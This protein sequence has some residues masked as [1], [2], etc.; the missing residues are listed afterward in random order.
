MGGGN[1]LALVVIKKPNEMDYGCPTVAQ[2]KYTL[3]YLAYLLREV[4][5]PLMTNSFSHPCALSY[6][7]KL[8]ILLPVRLII[9][10]HVC[11]QKTEFSSR[12]IILAE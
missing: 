12:V 1:C 4:R 7:V 9:T 2:F 11:Y 3:A 10:S 8:Y 6:S 5:Q